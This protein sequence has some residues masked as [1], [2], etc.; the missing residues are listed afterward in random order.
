[1]NE[2]KKRKNESNFSRIY[3]SSKINNIASCWIPIRTP[4]QIL[5][6]SIFLIQI[7]REKIKI[8][9]IRATKMRVL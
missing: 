6:I 7:M 9:Q 2:K 5:V 4:N 8:K 1:M 3:K